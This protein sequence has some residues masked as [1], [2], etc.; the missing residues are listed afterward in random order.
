MTVEVAR[1]R[2]RKTTKA[3]APSTPIGASESISI[4]EIEQTVFS[5]PSCQRPLAIGARHCP[6]CRT[7]LVNRVQLSKASL[8]VTVGLVLGLAVGGAIGGVALLGASASRDAEIAAAV[9]AALAAADV[10]PAP[11]ASAMPF[12]SSRP[13]ATAKPDG[14]PAGIPS[15]ARAAL[16]QASS[17]NAQMAA[18]APV[19]QSALAAKDFD[20]YTVFQVLR[21]V[22]GDAV[23]GRQLAAHIGSWAG[24]AELETSLTTFYKQVQDTAGEGLD[25]SIRN[26]AAYKTAAA[27]MIRLLAGV[28]ALDAQ[29]R[30]VAT[31]AGVTIP[32]AEAP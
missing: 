8:F 15:L 28:A 23:T 9:S 32:A 2:T 1:R 30:T 19:L 25:A 27:A 4:G 31:E 12:A 29:V 18:A 7:H 26:K 3:A 13:L 20:T 11:A 5:C 14:G 17:L 22:S 16:V 10:Q 6:G 24:G 21:S